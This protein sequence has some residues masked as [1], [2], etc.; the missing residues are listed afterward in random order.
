MSLN[1]TAVGELT[2]GIKLILSGLKYL[3]QGISYFIY[4]PI[5]FAGYS[6][7]PILAQL[8]YLGVLAWILKKLTGR[9]DYALAIII[10]MLILG[11]LI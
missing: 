3:A 5:R 6:P 4:L 2:P 1:T 8:I 9:W 11:A 7:S 10:I